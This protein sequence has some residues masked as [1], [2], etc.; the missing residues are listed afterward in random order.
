MPEV[1]LLPHDPQALCAMCSHDQVTSVFHAAPIMPFH[2][3]GQPCSPFAFTDPMPFGNH[4]CRKCENCGYGWLEEPA[5]E[6]DPM[7]IRKTGSSD[8]SGLLGVEPPGGE[9]ADA[10]VREGSQ[11]WGPGDEDGLDQE[12]QAADAPE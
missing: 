10:F 2:A 12:N 4:Q 7:S 8:D 3:P 6:G 5:T 9:D 11:K 1:T